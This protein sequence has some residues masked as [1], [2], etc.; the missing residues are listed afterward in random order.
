M[1]REWRVALLIETA[2]GYGRQVLRGIVDYA[3]QHGP[4]SFYLSP[5][6]FKQARPAMEQWKGTGIIARVSTPQL[7]RTI[8]ATGLPTVALDLSAAARFMEE[9]TLPRFSELVTNSRQAA[10]MAAEH[11]LAEGLRDFAF[12]GVPGFVW[13]ERRERGFCEAIAE[14]GRSATVFQPAATSPSRNWAKDQEMLVQ[15]LQSLP[16]PIGLMACNDDRGREVLEACRAARLKVPDEV[17]VIGVDNDSLLCDLS[18]PPLSSVAL[19]AERAGYE[20]AELLH[21]M[22]EGQILEPQQVVAEPLYV[23]R[24]RS[25]DVVAVEDGEVAAAMRFIRDRADRPIRIDDV[26]DAIGLSRR[27][28]EIRFRKS[29]GHSLNDEVQRIHLEKAK[30][31]LVETDWS[32][33]KIAES[34]GYNSASYLN[35]VFQRHTDMSPTEFRRSARVQ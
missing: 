29:M 7:A 11:L 6:D 32:I 22:M 8:Q 24:R 16:K 30:H 28:L 21:R 25:T 14:A 34:T 9:Q 5:G 15:W 23:V 31:L 3:N 35:V 20:S 12:V 2:R 1:N 10:R 33:A 27:T 17:A 18:C 19:N 4:W 26:A 13:S